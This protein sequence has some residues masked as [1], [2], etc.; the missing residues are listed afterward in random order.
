MYVPGTIEENIGRLDPL[1]EQRDRIRV[2]HVER[3]DAKVV[4]ALELSKRVSI[5]IGREYAGT[6]GRERERG[7]PS[8][9]LGRGGQDGRLAVKSLFHTQ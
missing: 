3:T 8:D 7:R 4:G 2:G 5:H 1:C 6:L 9:A